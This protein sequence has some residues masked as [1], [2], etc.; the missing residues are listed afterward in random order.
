M[1]GP[2]VEISFDEF[3]SDLVLGLDGEIREENIRKRQRP[4]SVSAKN[5]ETRTYKHLDSAGD[6]LLEWANYLA[7][8]PEALQHPETL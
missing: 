5:K 2:D 6:L 8:Q 1:K 3:N 7:P 4:W